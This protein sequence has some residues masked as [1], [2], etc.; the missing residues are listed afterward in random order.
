MSVKGIK[1]TPVMPISACEE[2]VPAVNGTTRVPSR[3]PAATCVGLKATLT[4]QVD[5]LGST[6]PLHAL[7]TENC[8]FVERVPRVAVPPPKFENVTV[9]CGDVWPTVRVPKLTVD[10]VAF[11]TAFPAVAVVTS[12]P[13]GA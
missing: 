9:C 1:L 3:P 12:A 2:A 13:A 8:L 4:W 11:N 5:R 10:G 7:L 6:T